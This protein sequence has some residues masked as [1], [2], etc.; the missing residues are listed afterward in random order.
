[1]D[2]RSVLLLLPL[3]AGSLHAQAAFTQQTG[4]QLSLQAQKLLAEARQSASG[5]A[6]IKL[7]TYPG[8]STMLTARVKS[9]GAELHQHFNDIFIALEGDATGVTG[10]IILDQAEGSSGE[11]HGS[12]IE[13]GER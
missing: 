10:G 6:G 8:H 5:S 12:R 2:A 9:G 4:R 3:S 7:A 13:G 1:M 11:L